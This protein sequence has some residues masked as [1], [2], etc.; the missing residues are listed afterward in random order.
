MFR[1]KYH[2]INI[3]R[4]YTE[5]KNIP[6]SIFIY[7]RIIKKSINEKYI[8]SP[9]KTSIKLYQKTVI[10][11]F[12]LFIFL[13]SFSTL[14]LAVCTVTTT[15]DSGAGSLRNCITTANGAPGTTIEFNIA[16]TDPNYQTSGTDHW[17]RITP[18]TALPTIST[19][20]TL[21]DGT[22]QTTNQGDTNSLGPEIEISGGGTPAFDGFNITSANNTIKGFVINGF[23]GGGMAGIRIDTASATGNTVV[24]NYIGTNYIGNTVVANSSGVYILGGAQNNTVGGIGGV[25]TRNVISGSLVAINIMGAG[26]DMN[27]IR[28]NFIGTNA[29]GTGTLANTYGV[30]INGGAQNNIIGGSSSSARNIIS[31]STSK[32]VT[33]SGAN[34]NAN[35]VS[36]NYIGTDF[37]GTSPLANGSGILIESSSQNNIIGGSSIEERNI[38]SGN[39]IHGVEIKGVNTSGNLIKGNYIGTDLNG[40]AALPNAYGIYIHNSPQSNTIGGTMAGERNIISGN[41]ANGVSIYIG[42]NNNIVKGNYIGTDVTGTTALANTA[43]GVYLGFSSINNIIGG[44]AAGAANV[45]AYNGDGAGEYGIYV[46]S[47][48]TDGNIISANSIFENFSSGIKLA[49]DGANNDQAA[50]SITTITPNGVNLDITATLT[51]GDTIEFFRANNSVTPVVTPDGSSAGEGFLFLGTCQDDTGGGAPACSGPYINTISDADASAGTVQVTLLSSGFSGNDY[52]TATTTDAINGTSEFAIN[53]Q[54]PAVFTITGKI[55]EDADFNG[56]ASDWDGGINDS[57]LQNVEVELYDDATNNWIKDADAQTNASGDFII[58]GISD[59][60]YKVRVRTASIA[61]ADT[62]PTGGLNATVPGTW[63]YPLPEMSWGNGN[64]LYGGQSVTVDD[65]TTADNASPGPGD[66][67]VTITVSGGNVSNVNFGFAYNLIVNKDDDSNANN[68]LSKQGSLRQFIKNANAIG[69]GDC[70]ANQTWNCSEFRIPVTQLNGNG[71]ATITPGIALPSLSDTTS[72]TSIDGSTQTTNIGDNNTN[73]PEIEI[74]GGAVS[75]AFHGF[76]IT[77][78]DNKIQGLTIGGFNRVNYAGILISG[79]TATNNRI[80]GNYIGTNFDGSLSNI[81]Y[82][83]IQIENSSQ[84]NFIGGSTVVERNVI[85]GNIKDGV[86]LIGANVNNNIISGNYIGTN[87]EGST[88]IDNSSGITIYDGGQNNIIGGSNPGEGN[89]ISGNSGSGIQI[90]TANTTNNQIKGNYIGTD[91]TATNAVGNSIGILITLGA[92]DN[93]IGSATA[94]DRNIISGNSNEGVKITSAGT[95]SNKVIGNYI[96][97]D[98]SGTVALP[99]FNGVNVAWGAMN[100]TVGGTLPGERN[101]ISGN[102]TY[103]VKIESGSASDNYVIGNYIGTDVTGSVALANRWGVAILATHNNFVGGPSAEERN[104]ISGN[105]ESG[106]YLYYTN[107]NSNQIKGNYIGLDVTGTLALPNDIHGVHI[108]NSAQNNVIGG[109]STNEGN[110]IAYNGSSTNNYGIYITDASSDGNIISGNSIFNNFDKGIKLAGNGANNDIAPPTIDSLV[111]IGENFEIATTLNPGDSIEFFRVNNS[112]TPTVAPDAVGS[113]EGFLFL[114]TCQDDSGGGA[115]SCGG[116]HIDNITDANPNGGTIHATL[117]STGL[118]SGDYVTATTTNSISGSSEFSINALI[119]TPIN[120]SGICK[121]F[122]QVTDCTDVGTIRVAVNGILQDEVQSLV[123]GSWSIENISQ[124][125]A[126]DVITVF[127]DEA[128]D[129]NE[130]IAISKYQGTGDITG[131]ELISQQLSLGSNNNVALTNSEI[132]LYDNSQSGDEDIFHEVDLDNNLTLDITGVFDDATLRIKSGTTFQPETSGNKQITAHNLTINGTLNANNNIFNISGNW[133]NNGV[134]N[135]ASSLVNFDGVSQVIDGSTTFYNLTKSVVT[136]DSL[137]FSAGHAFSVNGDLVLTGSSGQLLSLISSSPTNAWYLTMGNGTQSIDYVS[138]QNSDASGGVTITPVLGQS[139]DLGGNVNWGFGTAVNSIDAEITPNNI[140]IGATGLE[141]TYNL[142]PVINPENT[143]IDV[144]EITAPLG[145]KNL[146][147]TSVSVAGDDFI[148]GE[149]CP[150]LTANEYCGNVVDQNIIISLGTK[151]TTTLT[152]TQAVFSAD[153]PDVIGSADFTAKVNDS[154]TPSIAGQSVTAGNADSD[155][156]NEN[157]I[158][159]FVAGNA[160]TSVTGEINPSRVTINQ[161]DQELSLF[162]LPTIVTGNTGFDTLTLHVPDG[163]DY[164]DLLATSVI[165]GEDDSTE[166]LIAGENCP[167][168]TIGE[169]CATSSGNILTIM[170]ADKITIDQTRL[171]LNFQVDTP[172]LASSETFHFSVDD[173]LTPTISAQAGAAGDADTNADNGNTLTLTARLGTDPSLSTFDVSPN[174]VIADGKAEAILQ[175]V[176]RDGEN[177][178]VDDK[179]ITITSDRGEMDS[180]EYGPLTTEDKNISNAKVDPTVTSS[181]LRYQKSDNSG[182]VEARI[183]S[184]VGGVVTLTATDADGVEL[185]TKPEL[186]F[187]Q[188]DVLQLS[189]RANT[190]KVVVGDV[191]TYIID[192]Q[193]TVDRDIVSVKLQDT[194]PPNFKYH[195]GSARL[196]DIVLAD[197]TGQRTLTFDIGTLPAMVDSNRNGIADNGETGAVS[198][199]YQLVVGAGARPGDYPNRAHAIDVCQACQISNYAEAIVEVVVDPLFDLG[200]IIGKVFNDINGN[201]SQDEDLS[202]FGIANVM[203]VLDNGTYVLTDEHGRYHFPAV[204]P[205]DRLLKVNI[206]TLPK[207]NI[208]TSPVTQVVTV[209]P[210]LL[211]KANFGT[212]MLVIEQQERLGKEGKTASKLQRVLTDSPLQF[213]GSLTQ[214][215]LL[216]NGVEMV[217]PTVN[218]TMRSGFQGGDTQILNYR[219]NILSSSLSFVL[220][221]NRTKAIKQWKIEIIQPGGQLIKSFSGKG[222]PPKQLDWNG[223]DQRG[224]PLSPQS[225]YLYQLE[226]SYVDGSKARSALRLL[227]VDREAVISLTLPETVFIDGRSEITLETKILL[228]QATQLLRQFPQENLVIQGATATTVDNVLLSKQRANAAARYLIKNEAIEAD[229]IETRWDGDIIISESTGLSRRLVMKDQVRQIAMEIRERPRVQLNSRSLAVD[230]VGRFQYRTNKNKLADVWHFL[231]SHADGRSVETQLHLPTLDIITPESERWLYHGQQNDDYNIGEL[232]YIDTL[233]EEE[234]SARYRLRGKAEPGSLLTIDGKSVD[235]DHKGEFTL[236][237]SLKTGLN[238]HYLVVSNR[239]GLRRIATLDLTLAHHYRNGHPFYFDLPEPEMQLTIPPDG[240]LL[241]RPIY[242]IKGIT[243]MSHRVEINDQEIGIDKEGR[244]SKQL[245]LKPGENTIQVRTTDRGGFV[246]T[247][248]RTVIVNETPYFFMAFADGKISQLKRS[249]YLAGTGSDKEK[250]V[251]TEGRLAFYFKGWVKGKYLVTSAF[252]SGQGNISDIFSDLNHSQTERLLTNLDPETHYPVYGDDSTLV[253]DVQSR[254]KFYLAIESNT[255]QAKLGN[256]ALQWSETELAN[257]QRTLYGLRASYQS[258]SKVGNNKTDYEEDNNNQRSI[259]ETDLFISDVNQIHVRDEILTTGGSLYYLS[260][261]QVIEGSEQIT[262]VVRDRE[263]GLLLSRT[264]QTQNKDYTIDYDQGRL[265][266]NRPLSNLSSDDRLADSGLFDGNSQTLQVDYEY[267]NEDFEENGVGLRA[268]HQLGNVRLGGTYLQDDPGTGQYTLQGIDAEIDL[269]RDSRLFIELA[270][271]EGVDGYNYISEDGG[272]SFRQQRTNQTV[273]PT[274]GHNLNQPLSTLNPLLENSQSLEK[275][276]QAWKISGEMDVGAWMENPDRYKAA[277]Y[278][279]QLDEGFIAN[280]AFLEQG[281]QKAGVNI[282]A[283][284]TEQD[285]LRARIDLDN[286]FDIKGYSRLFNLQWLHRQQSVTITSELQSQ[287]TPSSEQSLAVVKIEK[288]W[289]EVITTSA[290]QQLTLSGEANKQTHMGAQIQATEHIAVEG[291][292]GVGDRGEAAQVGVTYDDGQRRVYVTEKVTE[293]NTGMQA[294]STI[295][296]SESKLGNGKVYTEHQWQQTTQTNNGNSTTT[297]RTLAVVGSQQNWDLHPGLNLK[298]LAEI[299]DIQTQEGNSKRYVAGSG[300]SYSQPQAWKASTYLEWRLERG[301]TAR[302]QWLSKN[303]IEIKLDPDYTLLGKLNISLT[304]DDKQQKTEAAFEERS[305]GLAYRPTTH[306]TFNALGRYSHMKDQRPLGLNPGEDRTHMSV[307][308]L[309]F[310]YDITHKLA[311]TEKLAGRIKNNTVANLPTVTTQTTLM[312]HRLDYQLPK[313]LG[314]GSE[315]R[316]LSVDLTQDQRSGW[317]SELTWQA[318]KHARLGVG[319]NFTDFSDSLYQV[320]SYSEKGWFL[321]IQGGW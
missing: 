11:R 246:S 166:T 68:L 6:L 124:P 135:A 231:L 18:T 95:D 12:I 152:P 89:V 49:G 104:I 276:G 294:Q 272:L 176:L 129:L 240:M 80:V 284:L 103:G 226:V 170:L 142:L 27:E 35:V 29:D 318:N 133:I 131:I 161:Q 109:V 258:E 312:I 215:T 22:S 181:N 85:S 212:S 204:L 47:V 242:T 50:P 28:G 15:A 244:F 23:N 197:P 93:I 182:L 175:V 277:F 218:V 73:G 154:K 280:G 254:G 30:L 187:T 79:A 270:A 266:F 198:L 24:G 255:L 208:L 268:S 117:L 299:G 32:G 4:R 62:I 59:G 267:Q 296:G 105:S 309:D 230:E 96:G 251:L 195:P 150:T 190:R 295:V 19:A 186:F 10:H 321:R 273:T 148:L 31:G 282:S 7:L 33:F 238:R 202:E 120:I 137:T 128:D 159:V 168:L 118:N 112:S 86:Y 52:L 21:I 236:P 108:G 38:I 291:K 64:A 213:V 66:T 37:N 44:T 214:F 72:G 17:W 286:S 78:S 111:P 281:H 162:I 205:G 227:G 53:M 107:A 239:Q 84:L 1:R 315:Y 313:A 141:F 153:A 243:D 146:S 155:V 169:Y 180:I 136:S 58:S 199:I 60:T 185:L 25:T 76:K 289:N 310:H 147:V 305:I 5:H 287:S 179:L 69:S 171:Q 43:H 164:A 288:L 123:S 114:G 249:G 138:P 229:R 98:S 210:G 235:V 157:S 67:Y 61:D 115:L 77:S 274:L 144:F 228:R 257:Y 306:D 74:D 110:V 188:G 247:I 221:V 314:I 237:L 263:T 125:S 319:Y 200:N 2:S 75:P 192:I 177:Q 163:S 92:H 203:V 9:Q 116:P 156:T 140:S 91:P 222:D 42:S 191:V 158:T 308:S 126:N 275:S 234:I 100:N 253:N 88:A 34:T 233:L 207:G 20:N 279:K 178:A 172:S 81:N 121:Q 316:I 167:V 106:V 262:L 174:T 196:G 303:A 16:N 317:L 48:G 57:A 293:D 217:L 39:S 225:L 82:R 130:A 206:G 149:S 119:V 65:T 271:S 224:K 278:L 223:L 70:T 248:E 97:T 252:D 99:N 41:T 94:E 13:F 101:I 297:D 40:T 259:T 285:Q 165:V 194:I 209:T 216:A 63:P 300:L 301:V 14:S 241:T 26:T 307:V 145:Y 193:N 290:E 71:V 311:W 211:T 54:A 269:S 264:P 184:T 3:P 51:S 250:E 102:T 46:E 113:G 260:H 139:A 189:K 83:G 256:F 127:I 283:K 261:N 134:F 132:A 151:V 245:Q 173:S 298:I 8:S 265:L 183:R 55:F 90:A 302:S 201:G 220:D 122:D 87:A 232:A 45:I 304:T 320:N 219:N 292:V 160:V 56:S 36:G 143:G